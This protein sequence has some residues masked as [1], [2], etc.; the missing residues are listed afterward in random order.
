MS[1]QERKPPRRSTIYYYGGF[2]AKGTRRKGRIWVKGDSLCFY[3]PKGE[4]DEID[5]QI[6]FSSM[7]RVF[8]SRDNYY[9]SDT[10]LINLTFQHQGEK[11]Y[12]LR[13]A[14]VT[15]IPRRRIALQGAWL[16]FLQRV[17]PSAPGGR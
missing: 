17:L 15:V 11:T 10:W 14:P 7:Q 4:G 8:L 2:P 3:V 12:T 6:P 16:S 13:F 1:E 9:G 5:L